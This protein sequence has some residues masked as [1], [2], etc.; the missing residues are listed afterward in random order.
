MLTGKTT[1]ST[2]AGSPA[3]LT[4]TCSS[5]PSPSPVRLS[6]VCSTLPSG[7]VRLL[8]KTKCLSERTLPSAP[9]TIADASR[10]KSVPVVVRMSHPSPTTTLV[11]PGASLVRLTFPPLVRLT[12]TSAP[13]LS[14]G[15]VPPRYG[16]P[17]ITGIPDH[18]SMHVL[19]ANGPGG[20]SVPAVDPPC[21]GCVNPGGTWSDHAGEALTVRRAADVREAPRRAAPDPSAAARDA[22]PAA[23]RPRAHRERES[24]VPGPRLAV[25][26]PRHPNTRRPGRA[27]RP[28]DRPPA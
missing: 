7:L 2:S 22:G 16:R 21:P 19:P 8:K 27:G 18:F 15:A 4:F 14:W 26:E 3:R 25:D 11:R 24:S 1:L 20:T 9:S 12:L 10:S 28:V 5:S 6:P 13:N 17:S 23:R